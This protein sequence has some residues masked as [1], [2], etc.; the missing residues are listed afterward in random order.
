[1]CCMFLFESLGGL[2]INDSLANSKDQWENKENDSNT[3]FLD[4]FN[5]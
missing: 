3:S 4:S 2:F 1:M 5:E